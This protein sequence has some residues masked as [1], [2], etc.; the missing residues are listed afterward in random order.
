MRQ[1]MPHRS[2]MVADR[3]RCKCF[4]H[5]GAGCPPN[6]KRCGIPAK[7]PRRPERGDYPRDINFI[8]RYSGE[9]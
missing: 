3:L 8:K 1:V 2:N 7:M 5:C 9:P 4:L 6:P